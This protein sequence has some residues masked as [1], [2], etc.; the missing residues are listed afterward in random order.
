MALGWMWAR[1]LEVLEALA[2]GGD[3]KL[4]WE[5]LPWPS[6]AWH[7]EHGAMMPEDA[8]Q[9]LRSYDAIL[10]GALGD[11][12]PISDAARYVLPDAVSLAPLLALR[13]GFDLWACE[14]IGRASCRERV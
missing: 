11:P 3:L 12:G 9:R 10:L 2:A 7:R 13:K 14:Q 5:E 8:L 1:A 4:G 6:T